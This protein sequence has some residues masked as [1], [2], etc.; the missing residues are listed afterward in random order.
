MIKLENVFK[1]FG[2]VIALSNINIKI[3]KGEIFGIVGPNGSGKTTILKSLIKEVLPDKGEI[4]INDRILSEKDKVKFAYMSEQRNGIDRFKV[5]DYRKFYSMIY[6]NWDDSLFFGLVSN[7]KIPDGRK[8][9]NMSIG[10]KSALMFALTVAANTDYV[11]LDEPTQHLDPERRYVAMDIIRKLSLRDK[12]V[13]IASHQMEEME[14]L[15]T[16]FA[17]ILNSILL[18]TDDLDNAKDYHRIVSSFN[19]TENLK[20]IAVLNENEILVRLQ[21]S[22][23]DVGR[24]PKLG[25]LVVGYLKRGIIL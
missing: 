7:F 12:T 23:L 2:N 6:P 8:F 11:I 24:Y 15:L 18:Y 19:N 3:P 5:A 13:I 17:I 20:K 4:Y 16:S 14:N 22:N 10:N 1:S 21:D 9:K 25:E